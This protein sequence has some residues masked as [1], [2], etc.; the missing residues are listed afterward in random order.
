MNLTQIVQYLVA[1]GFA[2][3]IFW[4][5]G[6]WVKHTTAGYVSLEHRNKSALQNLYEGIVDFIKLLKFW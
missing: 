3:F 2:L 5:L 4:L 1:F 6:Q